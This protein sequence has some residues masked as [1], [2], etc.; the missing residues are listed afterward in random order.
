MSENPPIRARIILKLAGLVVVAGALLAGVMLPVVGGGG[1]VARSSASSFNSL[2]DQLSDQMPAGNSKVLAADG[3]LIT[4]FYKNNRTLVQSGQ[5][6]DVMKKAQ[7]DIEDARFYEH[8]GLDVQGTLRALVSNVAAGSVQQGGS[9]L[10]QQLVKQT[11]LQTATSEQEQQAATQQSVGRKLREARLAMAMEQKYS[12][13]EILDRYLNTVYYGEGAYGVEAAAQTYFSVHAKDLTLPQAAMLAGLVQSPA[14]DDPIMHPDSAL[15]RR[16]EV[17]QRMRDLGHLTDKELADAQATPVQVAHGQRPPNGCVDATVG[18]FFCAYVHD[19]LVNQLNLTN[20]QIDNGGLT[21]QTT[22]RPDLQRSGDQGVLNNTPMGDPFAGIFTAV[23]PGTGHVLAMSDNRRYGCSEPECESVLF[24][25][26]AAAGAGSVYKLFTAAAALSQGFGV[27]YT[28]TAPQPYTS[29]VYKLNGGTSGAPY[30]VHNDN[31]G[32]AA[33][34]NMTQAITVSANTYFV[35]L[36]DALGKVEGPVKMAQAMGMH[37]DHPT[38]LADCANK[39]SDFGQYIIDN[40]LGSFTLGPTPTSPLELAN[41][42]ATVAA[43]GTRCDP[44]PVTKVVDATGQPLKGANGQVIDTADHCTPNAIPA[45]IANTLSNMLVN[46]IQSGTGTKAA[47]PGHIVA[48]KTGTT[49]SDKSASFVGITPDYAVSVM[50]FNPKEQADVGGHGGGLPAQVFHDAMAPI[51]AKEPNKPFPAP[52]PTVANGK[53]VPVPACGSVNDCVAA[54]GAA[55]LR[56]TITQVN[57]PQ[58]AGA[59]LGTNPPAGAQINQTQQVAI[60]TSNGAVVPVPVPS[61]EQPQ[62]QPQPQPPSQPTTAPGRPVFPPGF[63]FNNT[64]G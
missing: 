37:F 31:A 44:T 4:Y 64:G 46:V 17:L 19:Y 56:Y 13:D 58:P 62:P 27:N 3:S 36:E 45:G 22:L 14:N 55:G 18:G 49:E 54:L 39:C 52:D 9:T 26:A 20:D 30:I 25:T 11:L 16:N 53:T 63:P 41:A 6:A 50:Y 43:S 23:Q 21:I 38:Q 5:I 34:Y 57:G 10:T 42:Y 59:F 33:T 48:G 24:N 29:K 51:L 32:Y 12:K 60:L 35:G 7:V 28:I 61:P 47:I 8:S 2:P 40:Q 1:L 15:K